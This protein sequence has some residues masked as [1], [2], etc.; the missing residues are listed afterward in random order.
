MFEG[1]FLEIKCPR[2]GMS[3]GV[4]SGTL[5]PVV[6]ENGLAFVGI[7]GHEQQLRGEHEQRVGLEPLIVRGGLGLKGPHGD[8][9]ITAR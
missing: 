2:T 6:E 5:E 1:V 4:F 9:R 8:R 7:E 3:Y